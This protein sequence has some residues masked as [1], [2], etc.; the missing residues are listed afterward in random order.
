MA[1]KRYTGVFLA[2]LL[3]TGAALLSAQ[4]YPSPTGHVN[5]FAGVMK[6][7]TKQQLEGILVDLK[8]KTSVEVAVVTVKDM[9]GQELTTYAAGLMKAWGIGSKEKNE[10]VLLLVALKER[11]MRI[12]VG[13][14]ME[15]LITDARSGMI[16]DQYILPYLKK[17]DFDTGLSQGALALVALIAKDKGVELNGA[18]P[19]PPPTTKIHRRDGGIPFVQLIVIIFIILVVFSRGGGNSCLTAFFLGSLFG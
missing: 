11:K 19:A 12:E 14:G 13:Y 15:P 17:N 9:G 8:Q 5:D 3:L 1:L 7:E 16:R 18:A 2:L 6:P 4:N 10:G